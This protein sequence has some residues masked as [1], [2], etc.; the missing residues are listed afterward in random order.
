METEISRYTRKK[1]EMLRADAHMSKAV[2]AQLRRGVGLVPGEK[3]ELWS[4]LFEGMPEEMLSKNGV[5]T[6]AEW[7]VYIALTM[8]A[9][10]QQGY[11]IGTQCM[12]REEQ[13]L[14]K[15]LKL[16]CKGDE[17]A[18]KRIKRRFDTLATS[19]DIAEAAYHLRGLIS[20][21]RAEGIALDYTA[22]AKDMYSFQFENRAASVR[23]NWGQDFY[24]T[25]TKKNEEDETPQS[26][27]ERK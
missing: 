13:S 6:R 25:N 27:D 20:L 14:G 18:Q 4:I 9:L 22:L 1:L 10:H 8:F 17:D 12:H 5:P 7:A 16:L 19:D 15:A 26:K 2:L 24:R 11:D 23:L 3:P 21:L